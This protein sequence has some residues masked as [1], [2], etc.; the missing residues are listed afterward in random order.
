MAELTEQQAQELIFQDTQ[1]D[2]VEFNESEII[3]K[4]SRLPNAKITPESVCGPDGRVK[5]TATIAMPYKAIC[6]LYM[7]GSSGGNYIGTG[8]LTHRNKLYTAGHCVYERD[9]QGRAIGW[10]T[11]II[12]VPALSGLT[13]PY[14]RYQAVAI[15]ATRGWVEG[16]N[17]RYDMGAIKLSS[18]VSHSDL[19]KPSLGDPNRG[20]VCGYAGDRDTGIFQYRME[21]SLVKVGGQFK[22]EIDT[23][24]GQSGSPLLQNS[25]IAVGIH[26]YGGCPNAASDLYQSFIDTIDV[27]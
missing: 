19:I 3:S 12:V 10:M 16:G 5:V 11:S 13:E 4:F 15:T 2:P 18:S 7:K 14:G 6:K 9:L 20:E 8:W 25:V 27:W 26:N 24:G 21:H 23:F 1:G 22:Y 17:H